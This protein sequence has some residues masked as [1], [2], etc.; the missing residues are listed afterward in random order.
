MKKITF[1]ILLFLNF[2][3]GVNAQERDES[4]FDYVF[5]GGYTVLSPT[6]NNV[7]KIIGMT[8][9]QFEDL[10]DSYDYEQGNRTRAYFKRNGVGQPLI[11]IEQEKGTVTFIWM[12]TYLNTDDL[13]K[14]FSEFY[15]YTIRDFKVYKFKAK[16]GLKFQVS[17][18]NNGHAGG[19][20]L[21]ETYI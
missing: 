6:W 10:M 3:C 21:V 14:R 18:K 5:R 12:D 15:Q 9:G 4:G 19:S 7:V 20:V 1:T 13:T 2:F 17:V 16:N 8:Q 11:S